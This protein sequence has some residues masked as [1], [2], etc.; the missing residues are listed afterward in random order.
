MVS[1][2]N[3]VYLWR[4]NS[5]QTYP[6]QRFLHTDFMRCE[7]KRIQKTKEW[8]T[9]FLKA[10]TS[11]TLGEVSYYTV[12]IKLKSTTK[13]AI[14]SEGAYLPV[15]LSAIRNCLQV[16]MLMLL[17]EDK[18]KPQDFAPIRLI[19]PRKHYVYDQRSNQHLPV[20]LVEEYEKLDPSFLY[21]DVPFEKRSILKFITENLI[22][23]ETIARS[24]Q[25]TISGSPYVPNEFGGISF[26]SFTP[27]SNPFFYDELTKTLKLMQPPEFTDLFYFLPE[28]LKKGKEITTPYGITF[29][30]AERWTTGKN[31]YSSYCSNDYNRLALELNKRKIFSGEYSIACSLTPRGDDS[32]ELYRDI[33]TKFVKTEVMH[34]SISEELYSSYVNLEKAQQNINEDL[35]LQIAHEKELKPALD[36]EILNIPKVK[37]LILQEWEIIFDTLGISKTEHESVV[38]SNLSLN[39]ILRVAQSISREYSISVVGQDQLMSAF[40]LFGRSVDLLLNNP[41]INITR[42]SSKIPTMV[43]T[44]K[45]NAVRSELSINQLTITQLFENVKK[46]FKDVYALQEYV[47]RLSSLGYVYEPKSGIYRW[48]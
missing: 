24:L 26:S 17:P 4:R 14:A 25:S 23:D 28:T 6:W 35:L 38:Y 8:F 45:F 7:Q 34:P 18:E 27:R 11:E 48:L 22:D 40:D 43:E 47:D 19:R 44:E 16:E 30:H 42:Y 10:K 31:F 1:N 33:L 3:Q 2:I 13:A 37:K 21:I 5:C 39:N 41:E 9:N 15:G 36:Q 20:V 46:Y 12:P 29:Q 32:S